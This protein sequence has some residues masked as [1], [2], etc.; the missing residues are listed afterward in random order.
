MALKR[1]FALALIAVLA[2]SMGGCASADAA[3]QT[4][5]GFYLDTVIMLTA[6]TEDASALKDAMA[7]CARYEALLPVFR[8]LAENQCTVAELMAR[9]SQ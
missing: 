4:E 7:E 6:Y 9:Q 1:V 3:K 8:K 5:V 2:L